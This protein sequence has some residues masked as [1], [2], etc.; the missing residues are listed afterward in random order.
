M[1]VERTAEFARWLDGLKD[2]WAR[3][4]IQA[5]IARLEGGNP[6]QFRNLRGSVSELKIDAGKGYRVYYTQRGDVL[7][8]LLCGG[9]KATQQADIRKARTMVKQL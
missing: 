4:R 2:L 5:R 8:I 9:N 6:G 7:I 3:A 1:K